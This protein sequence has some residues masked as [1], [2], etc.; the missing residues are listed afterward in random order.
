MVN[1]NPET[2]STDYDTA[3]RLYFEPLTLED[4]LEVV[5]AEQKTG[6]VEGVIVQL[7]GQPPLGLARALGAARVPVVGTSPEAIH[8]AEDRAAFAQVLHDAGLTAPRYG[9]ATSREDAQKIAREIGYPVLVRPSYVLAGRRI[10][11]ASHAAP[12]PSHR[13]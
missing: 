6:R 8:L 13:P 2:V 12:P 3:G 10:A 1:C 5:S 4:V 11:I 9:T 7:G